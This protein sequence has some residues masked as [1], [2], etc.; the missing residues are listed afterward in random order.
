MLAPCF[1]LVARTWARQPRFSRIAAGVVA[2]AF[3]A[4]GFLFSS[5]IEARIFTPVLTLV[6]PG[7]LIALFPDEK[8]L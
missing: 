3:L 6:A 1:M 7:V 4:V 2:P 5:V 8:T